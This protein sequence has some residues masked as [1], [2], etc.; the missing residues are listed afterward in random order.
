MR[1]LCLSKSSVAPRL[2]PLHPR[3]DRRFFSKRLNF[4]PLPVLLVGGSVMTQCLYNWSSSSAST[5]SLNFCRPYQ[6]RLRCTRKIGTRHRDRCQRSSFNSSMSNRIKSSLLFSNWW[7][8]FGCVWCLRAFRK[9]RIR[10]NVI[11]GTAMT[12]HAWRNNQKIGNAIRIK[13]HV[14]KICIQSQN[15]MPKYDLALGGYE[16][17]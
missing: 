15:R 16:I 1:L 11:V 3:A 4:F 9:D 13:M 12:K 17:I 14:Q 8:Y 10:Q 7:M 2:R 6:V 5:S